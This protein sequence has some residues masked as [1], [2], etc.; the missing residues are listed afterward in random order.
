[1]RHVPL[2][3]LALVL[4]GGVAWTDEDPAEERATVA[5]EVVRAS[6]WMDDGMDSRRA[7]SDWLRRS[8]LTK[9]LPAA[10]LQDA[11]DRIAR[12]H[13]REE[14]A[15]E[16]ADRLGELTRPEDLA[17]LARLVRDPAFVKWLEL[18]GEMRSRARD[19]G[20]RAARAYVADLLEQRRENR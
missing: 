20:G 9:D 19:W 2:I 13:P 6:R 4:I 18:D 1:M 7:F 10:E 17:E 8:D 16:L 12:E 11:I 5:L 14:G 3:G 15:R